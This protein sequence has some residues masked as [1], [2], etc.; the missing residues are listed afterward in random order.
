MQ[1]Q[2]GTGASVGCQIVSVA[3]VKIRFDGASKDKKTAM[4]GVP[5]TSLYT[6]QSTTP[7][8]P[9]RAPVFSVSEGWFT[10]TVMFRVRVERCGLAMALELR[11]NKLKAAL[12]I[13]HSD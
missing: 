7:R 3:A 4:A 9:I 13:T 6:C 10:A 5:Q 8:L 12:Q 1:L 2:R 11:R